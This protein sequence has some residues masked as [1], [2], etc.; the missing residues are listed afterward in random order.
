MLEQG[1]LNVGQGSSV[2]SVVASALGAQKDGADHSELEK[3]CRLEGSRNQERGWHALTKRALN[4]KVEPYYVS[5]TLLDSR[6]IPKKTRVATMLIWELM[7]ALVETGSDAQKRASILGPDGDLGPARWWEGAQK[8]YAEHPGAAMTSAPP[9]PLLIYNDS[10]DIYRDDS[11]EVFSFQSLLAQTCPE[12]EK[13]SR[14]VLNSNFLLFLV[15]C[16]QL[17][18]RTSFAK[19]AGEFLAWQQRVLLEGRRPSVGFYNE[20][21][22]GARGARAGNRFRLPMA[23]VG[24]HGDCKARKEMNCFKRWWKARQVC[25]ACLAV[26]S[27]GHLCF[28]DFHGGWRDFPITHDMYMQ[29]C[30]RTG[31]TVSP[32]L[33]IPGLQKQHVFF[34]VSHVLYLGIARD[35]I[36]SVAV[37][38]AETGALQQWIRKSFGVE[39]PMT[40][41]GLDEQLRWLNVAFKRHVALDGRDGAARGRNPFTLKAL[42]RKGPNDFPELPSWLKASR[43]KKIAEFFAKLVP[44]AAESLAESDRDEYDMLVACTWAL[45]DVQACLEHAE[46]RT[47]LVGELKT[48]AEQTLWLFMASYQWLAQRR[49][50]NALFKFRP[51]L[52]YLAHI[53]FHLR[54]FGMN[55]FAACCLNAESFNGLVK[56]LARGTHARSCAERTL[57]RYIDYLYVRWTQAAADMAELDQLD[58]LLQG[59]GAE[60]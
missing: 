38:L 21:L 7:E 24:W 3:I 51:K 47:W 22:D 11:W 8:L 33:L 17:P 6:G 46:S 53:Y 1:V 58:V 25:D 28:R 34:D 2:A 40:L 57:H 16:E 52:H 5:F 32:L 27:P 49:A 26:S 20:A 55:P 15:P 4:V 35:A 9:V 59:S 42:G 12:T 10:V 56:R 23:I 30:D 29:M 44:V 41:D 37:L 43:C 45:A 19:E 54:D 14:G 18:S 36:A 50:G 13:L 31:D 39:L 60:T 48:R